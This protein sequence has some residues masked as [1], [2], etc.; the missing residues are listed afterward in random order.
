MVNNDGW[1]TNK[2]PSG[3]FVFIDLKKQNETKKNPAFVKGEKAF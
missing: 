3:K 1:F 2:S